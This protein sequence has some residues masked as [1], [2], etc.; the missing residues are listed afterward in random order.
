MLDEY[1]ID[2]KHLEQPEIKPAAEAVEALETATKEYRKGIREIEKDEL[3]SQKGKT[4]KREE[5]RKRF[6]A[7]TN[8][9]AE[10]VQGVREKQERR[11]TEIEAKMKEPPDLG[12]G[13]TFELTALMEQYRNSPPERVAEAY[14]EAVAAGDYIKRR[15][16]EAVAGRVFEQG[17]DAAFSYNK[18]KATF[19][20]Q[21]APE[22]TEAKDKLKA[23]NTVST[24]FE[25]LSAKAQ[26]T[27]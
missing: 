1:G 21:E 5:L 2:Q 8:T 27:S 14:Q 11:L 16:V 18:A 10:T 23:A 20:A 19:E 3:L 22:V 6:D 24:L 25:Y 26:E 15:A 4:Q 13:A 9:L 12:Q 7:T 17:T